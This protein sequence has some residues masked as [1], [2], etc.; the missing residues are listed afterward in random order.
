MTKENRQFINFDDIV[1]LQYRCKECGTSLTIPRER[2]GQ[3]IRTIYNDCP[4]C[5]K[6]A[7]SL[8]TDW[9][10][11]DTIDE[12]ALNQLIEAIKAVAKLRL[13]HC[14]IRLEIRPDEAGSSCYEPTK[15]EG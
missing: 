4:H 14:E 6:E 9:V 5:F 8:P 3:G 1:G 7:P 10:K 13:K 12:E 11:R 15:K 2:W